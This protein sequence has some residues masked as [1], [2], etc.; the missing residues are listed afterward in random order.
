MDRVLCV[1]PARGNSKGIPR[2]NM[3]DLNGYPLVYHS[4][5]AAVEAR[6]I[7]R[8]VV[9]TEDAEIAEYSMSVGAEVP[10]VRDERLS[11]DEVHSVHVVIDAIENMER[12]NFHPTTV[13]M[14]LPTCPLVTSLHLD[15]AIGL[16]DS[17][18]M[19]S[20]ISVC[21][22]DK[23]VTALRRIVNGRIEPII[24]AENY[25]IQRQ[26]HQSYVVNA[27]IYVSNPYTLR[28]KET[29]HCETVHPYIMEQEC[30]ID[31]NS[32]LDFDIASKIMSHTR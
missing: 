11:R 3:R 2:K 23:P 21:A 4:I 28:E 20:V 25:N 22:F 10:F 14:K 6:N 29:F 31:I 18:I 26:D 32:E 24:V 30:S 16:Y 9:S 13:V 12:L 17:K 5:R 1:I 15:E 19:D 27:A 8:V 7:D